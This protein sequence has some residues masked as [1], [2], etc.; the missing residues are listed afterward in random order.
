[1]FWTAGRAYGVL[2]AL[3]R[4]IAAA[5]VRRIGPPARPIEPRTLFAGDGFAA[6]LMPEDDGGGGLYRA[7]AGVAG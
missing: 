3:A 2:C 7:G 6:P 5:G 1:V 4:L